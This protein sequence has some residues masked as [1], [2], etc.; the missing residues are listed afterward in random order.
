MLCTVCLRYINISWEQ[1]KITT[2]V[3]CKPTFSWIYAHFDSFLPSAY[4]I[5]MNYILLCRCFHIFLD[6]TKFHLE[7]VNLMD[8]YK[9]TS[10]SENFINTF[11][12][13]FLDNKHRIQKKVIT[14]PK[15]LFFLV[16]PNLGSLSLQTRTKKISQGYSQLLLKTLFVLKITFK[17]NFCCL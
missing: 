9:I 10:Y 6:W 1:G 8:V 3:Y 5:V 14:M 16:L 17:N 4:K 12:K 2:S 7:L 11:F 15:K 13:M